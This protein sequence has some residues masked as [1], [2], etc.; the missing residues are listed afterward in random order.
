MLG[1][2]NLFFDWGRKDLLRVAAPAARLRVASYRF[3]PINHS[4]NQ[5]LNGLYSS[6]W[7]KKLPPPVRLPEEAEGLAAEGYLTRPLS[8]SA[9]EAPRHEFYR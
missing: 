7:L 1:I 8:F 6:G 3:L 2:W 4:T 5:L 9:A